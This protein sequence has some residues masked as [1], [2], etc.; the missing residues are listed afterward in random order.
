MLWC[1]K[2]TLLADF[3]PLLRSVLVTEC[4]IAAW[5]LLQGMCALDCLCMWQ[6]AEVLHA[7]PQAVEE[8]VSAV[9]S[10][11]AE[12]EPLAGVADLQVEEISGLA[13]A[14]SP[15]ASGRSFFEGFPLS[16]GQEV[17]NARAAMAGFVAAVV[18]E[19]WTQKSVWTQIA[20]RCDTQL[21]CS[22]VW[23]VWLQGQITTCKLVLFL[24]RS[25]RRMASTVC[26]MWQ[27]QWQSDKAGSRNLIVWLTP[28]FSAQVPQWRLDHTRKRHCLAAVWRCRGIAVVCHARALLPEGRD[29]HLAQLWPL[30]AFAGTRC[31]CAS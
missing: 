12:A 7:T 11:A 28:G 14:A 19:A 3:T 8:D 13:P 23:H 4:N 15:A 30:H 17:I 22:R 24:L 6:V 20:G 25:T 5:S 21:R 29:Q 18:S 16:Q 9:A 26:S 2:M 1:L 27:L 10:A 31:W